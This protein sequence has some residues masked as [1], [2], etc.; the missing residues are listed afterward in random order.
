MSRQELKL[1]Q[2][3]FVAAS[4]FVNCWDAEVIVHLAMT[5][6]KKP[7]NPLRKDDLDGILRNRF[8]R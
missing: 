6:E 3:I 4:K 5:L 7:F 8:A 1:R 2:A